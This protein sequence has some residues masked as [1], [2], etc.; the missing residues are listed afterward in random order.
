MALLPRKRIKP[1]IGWPTE[2]KPVTIA[3]PSVGL[4]MISAGRHAQLSYNLP[5]GTYLMFCEV[6][7]EADGTPHIFMGMWKV[8]TLR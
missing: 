8:I 2:K 3:G 7:D 5:R 6:P 4:M 1:L